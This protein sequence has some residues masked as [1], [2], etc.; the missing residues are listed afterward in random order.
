MGWMHNNNRYVG[1]R[2]IV[3]KQKS[4]SPALAVAILCFLTLVGCKKDSPR[5]VS[6]PLPVSSSTTP[7]VSATEQQQR[8]CLVAARKALGI[9]AQVVRCGT[10]NTPGVLE[11]VAVLPAKYPTSRDSSLAI[12]KMVILRHEPSGWRTALTASRQ[13]QNEAGYVGLEYIDDYFHF[14]GYQL[15]LWDKRPDKKA[16]GMDLVYIERADGG[17]DADGTDIAWNPAVG[18][19]QECAYDQDPEGFRPE[20]KNPPHWKPGVKLPSTPPH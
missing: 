15:S 10:L 14:M 8:D 20:I 19:Y 17:S 11:V 9:K 3:F 7:V 13:I 2:S 6:S 16:F 4:A 18:R 1:S 12:W 5:Q